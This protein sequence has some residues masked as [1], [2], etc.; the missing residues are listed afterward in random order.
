VTVRDDYTELVAEARSMNTTGTSVVDR[1]AD[2]IVALT[3][4]NAQLRAAVQPGLFNELTDAR[5]ELVVLTVRCTDA[6][7]LGAGTQLLLDATLAEL[8]EVEAARDRW[9][10]HAAALADARTQGERDRAKAH[11]RADVEQE[12]P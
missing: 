7:E 8:D 4:E 6:E 3:A 9:K 11:Y 5:A 12:Q 1:M 10:A 2:A